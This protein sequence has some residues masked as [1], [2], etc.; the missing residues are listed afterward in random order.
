MDAKKP[1]K[2]NG[3]HQFGAMQ[4]GMN[5]VRSMLGVYDLN[6]FTIETLRLKTVAAIGLP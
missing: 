2:T 3:T 5:R 1:L 4:Q 6:R